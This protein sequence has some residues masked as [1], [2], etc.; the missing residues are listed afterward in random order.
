MIGPT[1]P[2]LV[3]DST[4]VQLSSEEQDFWDKAFIAFLMHNPDVVYATNGA[5]VALA[6]RS[7]KFIAR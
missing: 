5:H 3:S 7:R 1:Y 2:N 4:K 6:Y